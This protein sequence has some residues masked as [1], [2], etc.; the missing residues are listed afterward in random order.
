MFAAW[1]THLEG[2]RDGLL[3]AQGD[4]R[5]GTRVDGTHRPANRGERG[6]VTTQG[7]LAAGIG[8]RMAALDAALEL[9]DR[10]PPSPRPKVV[11]GAQ[12]VLERDAGDTLVL[13]ILPGGDGTE[14]AGHVIVSPDAP[15][16]R[17]LWGKEP[18][19]EVTLTRAGERQDWSIETVA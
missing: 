7:Y 14:L 10:M 3:E 8:Q 4:A 17:A 6:A 2:V 15:V 19:D 11:T 1:R 5:A 12:V 13:A 18:G 9:L 16:A